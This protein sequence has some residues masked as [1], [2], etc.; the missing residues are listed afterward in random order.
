M[1]RRDV[2]CNTCGYP[3]RKGALPIIWPSNKLGRA[4]FCGV[5]CFERTMGGTIPEPQRTWH[6]ECEKAQ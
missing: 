5:E 4:A 2:P 6:L 3:V 1:T